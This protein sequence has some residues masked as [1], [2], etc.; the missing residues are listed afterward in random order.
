MD[1]SVNDET[2]NI[3]EVGKC[4]RIK[5]KNENEN[6]NDVFIDAVYKEYI[7]WNVPDDEQDFPNPVRKARELEGLQP[8][9]D[10]DDYST[11]SLR[12]F[13]NNKNTIYNIIKFGTKLFVFDRLPPFDP[14]ADRNGKKV[15]FD[16]YTYFYKSRKTRSDRSTIVN[17]PFESFE[18]LDF[19][20]KM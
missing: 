12:I 20:E 1:V 11:Y 5:I 16:N 17:I 13:P 6:T 15:L 3:F 2:T 14:W 10:E 18:Y 7:I 8:S 4:Y 9:Q 19:Q